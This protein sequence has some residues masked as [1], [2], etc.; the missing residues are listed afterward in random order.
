[1]QSAG[2]NDARRSGVDLRPPLGAEAVGDFAEDDRWPKRTF[3][4]VVRVR[5]VASGDEAEQIR[6]IAPHRTVQWT[7]RILLRLGSGQ[8]LVQSAVQLGANTAS[9]ASMA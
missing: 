9:P 6:T 4:G 2:G 3:A 1:M 7:G 8:Q 5:H